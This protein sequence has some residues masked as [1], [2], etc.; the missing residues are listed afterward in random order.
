MS[1]SN[2]SRRP[3]WSLSGPLVLF[4]P[5]TNCSPWPPQ[6][7]P[8]NPQCQICSKFGH[9]T[10]SCYSLHN[11]SFYTFLQARTPT[12]HADFTQ[13]ASHVPSFAQP[14]NMSYSSSPVH[15]DEG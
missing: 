10:L 7:R 15:P 9:T 14:S 13:I 11:L 2:N 8:P 12:Y 1:V 4:Y 3:K 5:P 6:N